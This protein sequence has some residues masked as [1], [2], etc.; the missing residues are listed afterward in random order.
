MSEIGYFLDSKDGTGDAYFC[1]K[2]VESN[3][4]STDNPVNKE[5]FAVLPMGCGACRYGGDID[6]YV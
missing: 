4:K 2:C 1:A 6:K 3:G 5:N